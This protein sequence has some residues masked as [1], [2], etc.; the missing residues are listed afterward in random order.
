ME[1]RKLNMKRN[2]G[3]YVLHNNY[4]FLASLLYRMSWIDLKYLAPTLVS[5]GV[6]RRRLITLPQ[7]T[8]T[9][10]SGLWDLLGFV[11]DPEVYIVFR[12]RV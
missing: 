2:L 10:S 12:L 5:A 9:L 1:W 4:R 11:Y 3:L 8:G 6:I 7:A